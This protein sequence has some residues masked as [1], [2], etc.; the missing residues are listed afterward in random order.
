V[1]C[2]TRDLA[3]VERADARYVERAHGTTTIGP[4]AVWNQHTTRSLRQKM[5]SIAAPSRGSTLEAP[6]RN[7]TCALERRAEQVRALDDSRA[8]RGRWRA[9][10]AA[11]QLVDC[12]AVLAEQCRER[13]MAAFRLEQRVRVDRTELREV[14]P[15]ATPRLAIARERRA[16]RAARVKNALNV[17]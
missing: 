6:A 16:R 12:G 11:A 4:A 7:V 1:R 5:R 14:R 10:A 15:Q 17:R 2:A 9:V 13:I 8:A 3:A